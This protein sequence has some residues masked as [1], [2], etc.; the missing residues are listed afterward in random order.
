MGTHLDKRQH[1]A[2]FLVESSLMF[3][4][5]LV[6]AGFL[7]CLYL[8]LVGCEDEDPQIVKEV[9]ELVKTVPTSGERSCFTSIRH[10]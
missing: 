7:V 5:L 2:N 6:Y 4:R 10:R 3:A 9:A 1:L 8:G